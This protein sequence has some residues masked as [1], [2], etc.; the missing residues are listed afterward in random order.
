MPPTVAEMPRN[1]PPSA[2]SVSMKRPSRFETGSPV[3]ALALGA[4][5]ISSACLKTTDGAC[6][7]R[8][9]R[10]VARQARVASPRDDRGGLGL[11]HIEPRQVAEFLAQTTVFRACPVEVLGRL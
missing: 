9:S 8:K 3:L 10:L 7:A 4:D 5:A 1:A 11:A 6:F 2:A